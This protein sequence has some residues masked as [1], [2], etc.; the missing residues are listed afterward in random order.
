MIT[1]DIETTI[2]LQIKAYRQ[3]SGKQETLHY[4]ATITR[5]KGHLSITI[6][7]Q[8][9][10]GQMKIEGYPDIKIQIATI[11]PI[12]ATG[13]EETQIQDMICE[14]LN[15]TIRDTEY[16]LDFSVHSTCPRAL[17]MD[18]ED[19]NQLVDFP[20]PYDYLDMAADL[21]NSMMY[22]NR[23]NPMMEMQ[24]GT[25]RLLVK[26]VKGDGL[27]FANDPYW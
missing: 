7:Y 18:S 8:T 4:R 26:I 3:I 13:K 25:R 2:V 15:M 9:L 1:F 6:N 5:F 22:G 27:T 20:N 21:D 16:P 17:K 12:K 14:T 23:G 11:G 19:P 10:I 24:G